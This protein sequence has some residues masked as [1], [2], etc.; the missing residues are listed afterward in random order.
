[1]Q[2]LDSSWNMEDVKSNTPSNQHY[3]NHI[4]QP[5]LHNQASW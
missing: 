1:L 5:N 2:L 4:M 3:H